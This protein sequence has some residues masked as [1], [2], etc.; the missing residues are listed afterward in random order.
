MVR[1]GSVTDIYTLLL[2]AAPN[3]S[4]LLR[5]ARPRAPTYVYVAPVRLPLTTPSRRGAHVPRTQRTYTATSSSYGLCLAW[6]VTLDRKR[7]VLRSANAERN[8]PPCATGFE[9]A[10]QTAIANTATENSALGSTLYNDRL[11]SQTSAT[12]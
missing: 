1:R 5:S 3:N 7:P 12:D 9:P 4:P 8:L 6:A 2:Q 10:D 11:P